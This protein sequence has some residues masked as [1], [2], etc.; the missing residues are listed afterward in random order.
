MESPDDEL[1]VLKG[2]FEHAPGLVAVLGGP[3]H[4]FE[5]ANEACRRVIGSAREV[6]GRPAREVLPEVIPQ[7][8]F[9]VLDQVRASGEPFIGRG[10]VARLQRTLAGPL[11]AVTLDIVFQPMKA[12]DGQVRRIFVQ[13]HDISALSVAVDAEREARDQAV[14]AAEEQAFLADALPNQVWTANDDGRI[15][16]VNQRVVDYFGVSE[17]VLLGEGWQRFVHA[18]DLGRCVGTWDRAIAGG[19][20]YECEFRLLRARDATYRWHIARA[21]PRRGEGGAIIRWYGS[22][23]DIDDLKRTEG[24]RDALIAALSAS[25]RELDQFAYVASHDLRAPLRGIANIAQWIEADLADAAGETRRLLAMLRQRVLRMDAMIDG[26]LEYSRAGRVRDDALGEVD[27][28]A[29]LTEVVELIAPPPTATI[30]IP[31]ELPRFRAEA[32]AL[33]QVWMNLVGNAVKHSRRADPRVVIDVRQALEAGRPM[34]RFSVGDNGPG[35]EPRFHER[36]WGLFQTLQPRDEVE[37]SGIGLTIAKKLVESRG[38]RIGV[39]SSPG[40]GATFWFTW[41]DYPV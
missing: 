33:Q 12:A 30:E 29:M 1:D 19:T 25:N 14:S 13:G 4:V 17:E 35:I 37:G 8:Y 2:L 21:L 20:P 23:T 5:L 27:L 28:G 40:A 24:E 7:G 38:G 31:R 32:I 41:P 39:E 6:L 26:V 18:D 36:I 11:E 9:E 15:A 22:N 3:D 34:W 16:T 10:L